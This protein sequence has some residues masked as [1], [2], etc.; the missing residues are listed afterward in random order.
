MFFAQFSRVH[1]FRPRTRFDSR[2]PHALIDRDPAGDPAAHTALWAAISGQCWQRTLVLARLIGLRRFSPGRWL[3]IS[4]LY[5][6]RPAFI[7][8]DDG[9]RSRIGCDYGLDLLRRKSD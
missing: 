2:Q 7:Y 6:H 3:F 8:V 1:V 9:A 4:G 5:P